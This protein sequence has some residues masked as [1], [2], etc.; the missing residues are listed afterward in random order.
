MSALPK[1]PGP[2]ITTLLLL[3]LIILTLWLR[4]LVNSPELERAIRERAAR[5]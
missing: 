3:V 4:H 2:Y 5:P 1:R